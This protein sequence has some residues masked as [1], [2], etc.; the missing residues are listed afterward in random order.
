[1]ALEHRTIPDT[2]NE[3]QRREFVEISGRTKAE[4]N[5]TFAL[6]AIGLQLYLSSS[7]IAH[8]C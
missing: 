3:R 5:A 1:M 2:L 8:T 7:K 6:V 4:L